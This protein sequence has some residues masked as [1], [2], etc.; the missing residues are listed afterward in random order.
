MLRASCPETAQT[1]SFDVWKNSGG[2][3]AVRRVSIDLPCQVRPEERR[4][5][6]PTTSSLPNQSCASSAD[7]LGIEAILGIKAMR[8]LS[9]R[10]AL[11]GLAIVI[12]VGYGLNRGVLVGS[13]IR[14]RETERQLS[15]AVLQE[16]L[17][18][19]VLQRHPAGLDRLRID[20]RRSGKQLLCSVEK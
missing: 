6:F 3:E 4:N 11:F 9:A 15:G 12:L 2:E 5:Q 8:L 16:T 10:W 17:S 7:P 18:L 13:R 20:K 14:N 1:S 19:P